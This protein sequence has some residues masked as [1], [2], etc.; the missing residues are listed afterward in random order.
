MA[1]H[2]DLQNCGCPNTN[3]QNFAPRRTIPPAG[4]TVANTYAASPCLCPQGGVNVNP[5]PLDITCVRKVAPDSLLIK[6]KLPMSHLVTGYEIEVDGTLK[7]RVHNAE[8]N[9]AV[10]HTLLLTSTAN[11]N[12]FA[13]TRQGR[14]LPPATATF[15]P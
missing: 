6:W 8:R 11:I 7:S 4:D 15:Q 12:L 2:A 13:V 3:A 10:I 5:A 14:C 9:S 1:H